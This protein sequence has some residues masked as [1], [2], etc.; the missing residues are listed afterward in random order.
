MIFLYKIDLELKYGPRVEFLIQKEDPMV[1]PN[2][3][4]KN[5]SIHVLTLQMLSASFFTNQ[6]TTC[7][8]NRLLTKK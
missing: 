2:T 4:L 6:F 7:L 8:L 1:N 5:N 3:Q